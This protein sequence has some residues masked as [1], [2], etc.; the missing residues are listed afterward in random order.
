MCAATIC[1]SLWLWFPIHDLNNKNYKKLDIHSSRHL[2]SSSLKFFVFFFSIVRRSIHC[3]QAPT[4]SILA[5]SENHS[6]VKNIFVGRTK[7]TSS[8]SCFSH[9]EQK[10]ACAHRLLV[11]ECKR[12][13][14]L[15]DHRTKANCM[16]KEQGAL[17]S[18]HLLEK[19]TGDVGFE[20]YTNCNSDYKLFHDWQ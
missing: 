3:I 5:M 4:W 16:H 14:Y 8:G 9:A 15:V 12:S 2:T 13:Y 20:M 19:I 1:F 18:S 6:L 17:H 10:Y 7:F 11:V